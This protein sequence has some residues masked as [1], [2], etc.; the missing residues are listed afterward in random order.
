MANRRNMTLSSYLLRKAVTAS[1]RRSTVQLAEEFARTPARPRPGIS[2]EEQ[3]QLT[4]LLKMGEVPLRLYLTLVMLTKAPTAEGQPHELHR[5]YPPSQFAEML[6]Y[7][8]LDER[9]DAKPG[10]GTRRIERALKSLAAQRFIILTKESRQHHAKISVI[11]PAGGTHTPPYITLPIELWSHGWITELSARALA[12]YVTLRLVTVG[13]EPG[14]GQHVPPYERDRI[15]LSND[16]WQRGTRELTA[17]GILEISP[18]VVENRGIR[19]HHRFVYYL[20]YDRIRIDLPGDDPKPIGVG[21]LRE[22][23]PVEGR[24]DPWSSGHLA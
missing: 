22:G 4:I 18:G 9:P 6:G 17:L 24:S 10:A 8:N 19:E 1:G 13:K 5:I 16:T 3:P 7:E 23:S 12:V 20:N 11:H 15:G 21:S 14:E 2:N